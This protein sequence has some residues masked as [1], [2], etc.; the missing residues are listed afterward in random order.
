M[1]GM[2]DFVNPQVTG[3]ALALGL[4]FLVGL[5]RE[6][7]ANK[8]VGLRSFTLIGGS[9]GLAALLA[10]RWG[11]WVVAAGLFCVAGMLIAHYLRHRPAQDEPEQGTTTMFA[12]LAVYLVGAASVAGFQPHAVV[13]GG[14]ITLLL[15]WKQPL[16][17]LVA[18]IG[19]TEFSAIVRFVLIT[20]VVLPVL[21]N[22]T[23]GPYEVLNPFQTWLLVVLI[24]SLNLVGYVAFRLLRADSGAVLAGIIGGLV[25]STATTV[26]FAAMT[27]RQDGLGA[28]AALIILLASTVVYARIAVELMVVA[29]AL[30]RQA[31]APFAVFALVML[32]AAAVVFPRVRRQHVELPE[33]ENP[34]RLKV[35]LTFA[36]L[37]ALIIFSVAAA[38]DFLG[39]DAIYVVAVISGLTDVDALTL[40]VAQLYGRDAL[41]VD[42]A[43]RSI[44]LASLANLLF[45]VGAACVLGNAALRTYMLTLGAATL[46]AGIALLLAWP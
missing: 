19:D 4:G 44:F 5:E 16:H 32:V 21:P 41:A 8:P 15:H 3:L 17:G 31:A 29:P 14:V 45:K 10:E 24:V 12:A 2:L 38:R 11:A 30:L 36:A 25:S 37:Y 28:S 43:W 6:W 39:N 22:D 33:Q 35:A 20:L 34:A 9:G 40:S 27:R 18:R 1:R 13:I 7:A 26:S 46:A 23:F 42:T